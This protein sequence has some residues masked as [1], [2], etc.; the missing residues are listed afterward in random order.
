LSACSSLRAD[1]IFV[2]DSSGSIESS[3][4]RNVRSFVANVV[5]AFDISS[6]KV[7]VGLIEFSDDAYVEFDLE[8]YSNKR[9]I[10]AAIAAI[11]YY[12]SGQQ[13][14]VLLYASLF[15]QKQADKKQAN[16]KQR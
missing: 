3:N 7:R 14:R 6:D 4:F 13:T 11:P 12:R 2:V 1:V 5:D 9:S 15:R 16:K 8:E 10:Q